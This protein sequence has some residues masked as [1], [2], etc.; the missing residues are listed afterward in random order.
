MITIKMPWK[1][2]CKFPKQ[3]NKLWEHKTYDSDGF[4]LRAINKSKNVE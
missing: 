1:V 4:T 2:L 3:K